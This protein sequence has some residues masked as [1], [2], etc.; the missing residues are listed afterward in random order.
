MVT[1][2]RNCAEPSYSSPLQHGIKRPNLL[3]GGEQRAADQPLEVTA[4]RH[5]AIEAVEIGPN[6]IDGILLERGSNSAVA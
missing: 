1:T 5:Q 2:R 6:D 3:L 4:L